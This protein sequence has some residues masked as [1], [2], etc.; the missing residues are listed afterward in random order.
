MLGDDARGVGSIWGRSWKK[1]E[2]VEIFRRE[3][4]EMRAE[5]VKLGELCRVLDKDLATVEAAV[6]KLST[7]EDAVKKLTYRMN[8]VEPQEQ[9]DFNK[10][11][12]LES[13]IN[14][15]EAQMMSV[16]KPNSAS[17]LFY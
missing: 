7:L 5:H 1:D 16:L 9:E 10:L 15:L 2:S 11:R 12:F 3:L 4:D 17:D 8:I 13:R 14:K 6:L